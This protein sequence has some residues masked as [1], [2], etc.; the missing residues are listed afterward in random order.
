MIYGDIQYRLDDDFTDQIGIRTVVVSKL[1]QPGSSSRGGFAEVAASTPAAPEIGGHVM[2]VGQQTRRDGGA[3]R[4]T[5]T[6]EGAGGS[7]TDVVFR[8]RDNSLD[9]RFEPGFAQVPIQMHP[10]FLALVDQYGGYPDNDGARVIWPATLGGGGGGLGLAGGDAGGA[11]NPMFGVQDFFRM[12]GVYRFRYA[13]KSL[14]GGL[15]GDVGSVVGTGSLPGHPP[16][17]G[18]GRNWLK[19]PPP[20]QRRGTIYEI[21]EM[22][23]LS[24]PGGWPKPVYS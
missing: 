15:Y 2:L 6:F 4:T 11:K 8:G 10:N 16:S 24:G 14:P 13:A 23:W 19:M 17:V 3:L 22:Y 12:E 21:V 9:Y 5:W 20:Y 18:E 1:W 7:G